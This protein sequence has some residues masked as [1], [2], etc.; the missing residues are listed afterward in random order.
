M[1][2]YINLATAALA[3][4][5]C[6]HNVVPH[7]L[8]HLA[9]AAATVPHLAAKLASAFN[10]ALAIRPERRRVLIGQA[11]SKRFVVNDQMTAYAAMWRR[12]EE[13]SRSAAAGKQHAG[14]LASTED[15]YFAQTWQR[16][17]LNLQAA[18][19]AAATAAPAVPSATCAVSVAPPNKPS[20]D[21]TGTPSAAGRNPSSSG[22]GRG[23]L[24]GLT[25][26]GGGAAA[27]GAAHHHHKTKRYAGDEETT[28]KHAFSNY[29][30]VLLQSMSLMPSLLLLGYMLLQQ[31]SR[32]TWSS[33]PLRPHD[34][35][36][37][38]GLNSLGMRVMWQLIL[39]TA[40]APMWTSVAFKK[41]P[42]GYILTVCFTTLMCLMIVLVGLIWQ[43]SMNAALLLVSPFAL[44]GAP[45]VSL[46]FMGCNQELSEVRNSLKARC[47]PL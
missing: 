3:L 1:H 45:L 47:H 41:T 38:P 26:K 46:G 28:P 17:N 20:D 21:G 33:C 44:T 23:L 43:Q 4:C 39:S 36:W 11:L 31:I 16:R 14:A 29:L 25:G 10:A 30:V 22:G 9:A 8:A 27:G 18:A 6:T 34:G 37:L 19:V 40:A 5:L 13:A 24:A 42:K 12:I 35:E 2:A 7:L 32:Q 15:A